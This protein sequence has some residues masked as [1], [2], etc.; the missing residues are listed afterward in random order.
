MNPH[1]SAYSPAGWLTQHPTRVR[2]TRLVLHAVRTKP[3]RPEGQ[4]ELSLARRQQFHKDPLLKNCHVQRPAPSTYLGSAV[5]GRRHDAGEGACH[6]VR[7]TIAAHYGT[8][9]CAH[10]HSMTGHRTGWGSRLPGREYGALSPSPLLSRLTAAGVPSVVQDP[11][12]ARFSGTSGLSASRRAPSQP[13]DGIRPLSARSPSRQV[14][15]VVSARAA[16]FHWPTPA[17]EPLE[18][19]LDC[20]PNLPDA[21]PSLPPLCERRT[22][23]WV[24]SLLRGLV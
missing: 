2:S 11:S 16:A 23:V 24:P 22:R 5:G 7:T 14:L 9:A 18:R 20:E 6:C 17:C 8:A 1:I 21:P 13:R 3:R 4:D 19:T 12:R 10:T 15:G